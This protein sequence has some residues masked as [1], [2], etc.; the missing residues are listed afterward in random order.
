MAIFAVP[1]VSIHNVGTIKTIGVTCDTTS[2]DWGLIDPGGSKDYTVHVRNPGTAPVTLTFGTS[3]WNPA[4]AQSYMTLTWN[5]TGNQIT[6]AW[7]PVRFTLAVS[8]TV[9]NI[10]SFSFDI[11]IIGTG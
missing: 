1:S 11:T 8:P 10:T 4:T 2:I 5:Y 9:Q 3:N 7:V 6:S